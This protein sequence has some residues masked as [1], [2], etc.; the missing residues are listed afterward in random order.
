MI[1]FPKDFILG[2]AYAAYQVEGAWNEDGK[3]ASI[4]DDFC[5]TQ[6]HIKNGDTGDIACDSYHKFDEDVALMKEMGV[7]VHRFSL[8][9]PRIFPNGTGAVNEKGIA[10]YDY[11]VDTLLK[12]GIEPW[13]TLYHWD[14]PSALQ[15]KGGWESR[16]TVE[17]FDRYAAYIGRHFSRRV[18]TY[19][20]INEPE[21]VAVLGYYTGEHAPG[22]HLADER[23]ALIMH[24]LTLAHSAA[25]RALRVASEEPLKIGTVT[26]GR[27]CY[28]QTES[29]KAENAAYEATFD[30]S[31]GDAR[32]WGF[33][34]NIFLDRLF[35]PRAWGNVSDTVRK[36]W[37]SQPD[38]DWDGMEKPDFIGLNVY[39]G[40]MTDENG[41]IIPFPAGYPHTA[42]GWPITPKMMY[43]APRHFFKRYGLP[44]VITENGLSCTDKVYL[45]GQV[46]DIDR[47]DFLTRYL[48][49][50]KRSMDSGVPILGYLHWSLLDNF[51][52]AKG[53]DDR[54][55]LAYVDYA[56][57]KRILKDSGRW[58]GDLIKAKES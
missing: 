49:E 20:P 15:K 21:C 46:H 33:T 27:I 3:G 38:S 32:A 31:S 13:V 57:G 42:I 58:Y 52:W 44:I 51:E 48:T 45:D 37:E 8:S 5:H 50:L 24:H 56:T 9:W 14:L 34:H 26:C 30:L 12:N 53:Y 1:Q 2:T 43:Y 7:K 28:P 25:V 40:D 47:I 19:M 4:W 11:M 35:F 18:H 55:G 29:E 41:H 22:L 36:V 6:G 54:F 16:E 17:A 10:Y 23:I 39:N